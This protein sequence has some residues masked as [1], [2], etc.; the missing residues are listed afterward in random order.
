MLTV[1]RNRMTGMTAIDIPIHDV[2]PFYHQFAPNLLRDR[3][4]A[5]A[6]RYW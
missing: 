6:C 5:E 1:P 2:C 4:T 3:T